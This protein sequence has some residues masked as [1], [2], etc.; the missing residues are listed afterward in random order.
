MD[1][2]KQA[3]ADATDR[4]DPLR[5]TYRVIGD[6][7]VAEVRDRA[8]G[9]VQVDVSESAPGELIER[10]SREAHRPFDLEHGPVSRATL[11]TASPE[12]HVLLISA[13]HIAGDGWSNRILMKEL[14]AL[15]GAHAAGR[16]LSL[17]AVG[18]SCEDFARWQADMLAGPDGERLWTFWRQ[19]LAGTLPRLD[20][21]V[22]RPR[23]P[24]RRHRGDSEI[25]A[26]DPA[27]AT[28]L[29]Q[30]ARSHGTTLFVVLLAGFQALLAR[31]TGQDDIAVGSVAHGR[32]IPRFRRTF[33]HLMNQIV[34]RTDLIGSAELC[35]SG[36][37]RA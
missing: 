37:S 5:T 2:L 19:R 31:Y 8:D 16:P 25:V 20:L 3:W 4:N 23:K 30:L 10:V 18:A 28:A 14:G 32:T 27:L 1:A 33:G 22:D 17:P 29:R 12:D 6:A 7:I 9:L 13:H 21:P 34:L 15:Y 36:A 26:L 35:R 11:F 24:V